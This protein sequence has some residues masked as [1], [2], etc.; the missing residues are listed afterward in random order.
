MKLYGL[1]D[2]EDVV[3]ALINAVRKRTG[4]NDALVT[5][6]FDDT[7]VIRFTVDLDDIDTIPGPRPTVNERRGREHGIDE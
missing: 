5:L 4:F 3:E 1:M 2:K 7:G 6:E